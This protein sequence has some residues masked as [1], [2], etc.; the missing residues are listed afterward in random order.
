MKNFVNFGSPPIFLTPLYNEAREEYRR[1]GPRRLSP[2]VLEWIEEDFGPD[3]KGRDGE[4]C[5]N[6]SRTRI[7][8]LPSHEWW[9]CCGKRVNGSK[10]P[11]DSPEPAAE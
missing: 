9:R 11:K 1:T 7:L 8:S 3:V 6:C 2:E 4:P 5:P 10:A